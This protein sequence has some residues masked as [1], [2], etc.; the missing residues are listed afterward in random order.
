LEEV[1]SLRVLHEFQQ[2]GK[3]GLVELRIRS[4]SLFGF[5]GFEILLQVGI[6]GINLESIFIGGDGLIDFIEI[7]K[8][9]SF[10]LVASGPSR[11]HLDAGF[12]IF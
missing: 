6:I 5:C 9:C 3:V 11:I 1:L 4:F 2:C 7:E 8:C 12:C 10:A